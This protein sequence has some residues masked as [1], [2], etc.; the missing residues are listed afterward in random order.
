[1]NF[2]P[3]EIYFIQE[4]DPQ[5]G[6]PT[7]YVKIGLVRGSRTTAERI[8][9]HQ[10]GNPRAL[11]E[12]KLIQTPAVSFVE[13]TLH[14]MFAEN[15]ITGGEWFI[16]TESE[17]NSCLE[18][19][20][21]LVADVKKQESVFA[22]AAAFKLKRSKKAT[23]VPTKQVLALHKEYF[24]SD[25]IMKQLDGVIKKYEAKL[26]ERAAAGDDVEEAR[27]QKQVTRPRF[28]EAAFRSA[29]PGVYKKFLIQGSKIKSQFK[30]TPNSEYGFTMSAVAPK[31]ETFISGFYGTIEQLSK[32]PKVLEV[33]KAKYSYIK[34]EYA[35][36]EWEKEKALHQI[37]LSCANN[38]GINGVCTWVRTAVDETTFSLATLKAMRPELYEKFLKNST[39]TMRRTKEGRTPA[40]KKMR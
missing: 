31:L 26:D 21:T 33:A 24:K 34:G 7:K 28:D 17:L 11:K 32:N 12:T 30:M 9:E 2:N 38:S 4:Y 37:Q 16:F 10:T 8:K 14:Q 36:A 3:G 15:R 1:M 35:R 18:T 20:K 27:S 25:F 40:A 19:A 23:I 29:M 39:T 13:R 6:R 22:A 5:T